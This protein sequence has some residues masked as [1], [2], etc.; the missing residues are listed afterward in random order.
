MEART[1]FVFFILS[2]PLLFAAILQKP[3]AEYKVKSTNLN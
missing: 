1:R 3:T 2:F